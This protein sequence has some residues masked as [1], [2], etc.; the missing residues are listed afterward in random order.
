MYISLRE[1]FFSIYTCKCSMS[2]LIKDNTRCNHKQMYPGAIMSR[3]DVDEN[4][5]LSDYGKESI[6]TDYELQKYLITI[7]P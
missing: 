3:L 7:M 6:P 2:I 5:L 4:K 1:Q